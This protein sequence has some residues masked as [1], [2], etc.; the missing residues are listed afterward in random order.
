MRTF[1]FLWTPEELTN[2][3]E[4][5]EKKFSKESGFIQEDSED[6][7]DKDDKLLERVNT[8]EKSIKHNT[9]MLENME[10]LLEKI[11]VTIASEKPPNDK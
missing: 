3:K 11:S 4:K 1:A 7:N 5:V 10:R 8:L 9:L 2:H 6:S